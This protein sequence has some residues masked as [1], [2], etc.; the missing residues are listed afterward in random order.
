MGGDVAASSKLGEGSTFTFYL[1]AKA[2]A[3]SRAAA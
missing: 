2:A 1:P 3:S